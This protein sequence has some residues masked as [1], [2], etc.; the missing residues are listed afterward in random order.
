[1]TPWSSYED[2][3]VKHQTYDICRFKNEVLGLSTTTG[4]HVV[5]RAE[6]EACQCCVQHQANFF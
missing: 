4:D 3:L 6:L 2:L 1:M 5:T